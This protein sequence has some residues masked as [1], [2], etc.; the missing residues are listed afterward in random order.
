LIGPNKEQFNNK[1]IL[2]FQ[3]EEEEE[4][5]DPKPHLLLP[6][7]LLLTLFTLFVSSKQDLFSR[8][9]QKG[10]SN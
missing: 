7:F 8:I 6:S 9:R 10:F 5:D 4:E 1:R 3:Q 2:L